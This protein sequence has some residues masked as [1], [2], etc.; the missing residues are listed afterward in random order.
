MAKKEKGTDIVKKEQG[1]VGAP[2][3]EMDRY[4]SNFFRHPFGMMR[5]G[6]PDFPFPEIGEMSPSV[7][8]YE[9]NEEVVVKAELPGMKKEDVHISVSEKMITISGEKKQEEK[10]EKKD[11]HQVERRYGSFC[12]KLP[13]PENVKVED[14][15]ASF[16]DGLLEI[17]LPKTKP[18]KQK[19]IT[20]S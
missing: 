16:N 17:R 19:K 5:R 20:I 1:T 8:V 13:L 2:F 6:W 11:F 4:M 3:D 14:A 15:K 10:V 9:E 12:R 7:D 18:A